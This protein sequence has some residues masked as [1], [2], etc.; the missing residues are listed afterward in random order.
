MSRVSEEPK[1]GVLDDLEL[2]TGIYR[3]MLMIRGF[4][5]LV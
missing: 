3:Q 1:T 4:E 5:E 2:Y